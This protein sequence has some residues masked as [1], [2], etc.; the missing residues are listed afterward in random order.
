MSRFVPARGRRSRTPARDHAQLAARP[1]MLSSRLKAFVIPTSQ[2]MPDTAASHV[3]STTSTDSRWRARFPLRRTGP[4]A[5]PGAE[6]VE[7]VER[8]RRRRGGCSRRGS[9]TSS[10]S[11]RLR[12]HRRSRA[13]TPSHEPGEDADAPEGGVARRA[14]ARRSARR[15]PRRRPG[16]RRSVQKTRSRGGE[17]RGVAM[18]SRGGRV[19]EAVRLCRKLG[20]RPPYTSRHL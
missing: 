18:R 4:R 9:P 2:T 5:Y 10:G 11:A 14:S 3:R 20:D 1:S 17:G 16:R 13:S 19:K 6:R 12:S 7:V 8:A 15:E